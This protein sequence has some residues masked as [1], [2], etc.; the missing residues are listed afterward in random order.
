M[1]NRILYTLIFVGNVVF[2]QDPINL[3]NMVLPSPQAYE[4]VKYGNVSVDESSGRVSPAIPIYNYKAGNLELPISLN[5]SGNGVKVEQKP[6]WT[7]INWLL[8]AGGVITRVV[9][10][11]P[12]ETS[13]PRLF[14]SQE[15]LDALITYIIQYGNLTPPNIIWAGF[16]LPES[17]YLPIVAN[18][19]TADS[20]VDEFNFSFGNYSGSFFLKKNELGIFEAKQHKFSHD[21]KIEIIGNFSE[22]SNYEFKVTAPNGDSYFFGGFVD[23]IGSTEYGYAIEE[24]QSVDRTSGLPKF[25]KRAKTAFYLTKIENHLGDKIFLEYHTKA[26]HE[27]IS[28]TNVSM[29]QIYATSR[30]ECSAGPFNPIENQ[31]FIKNIVYNAKFLK[32]IWNNTTAQK[33]I[34][35]SFEVQ[36]TVNSTAFPIHYRILSSIDYGIGLA[37][38]EYIPTKSLLQNSM[39]N[40]EKFFLEKVVFKNQSNTSTNEEYQMEYHDPLE[41]PQNSFSNAQDYYGYYNGKNNPTLIP[42]EISY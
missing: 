19:E 39:R 22:N 29:K 32:Q 33:I 9:K 36:K 1:K 42:N 17:I 26:Q 31:N 6:T 15:Q 20:Q 38:F 16:I 12:D 11:L 14:Y 37:D 7:G 25:G 3:P 4:L 2:G 23:H 35:N 10:D 18:T 5:Y 28:A 34:F 40:R 41:I 13:N 21:L 30:P 27:L 24:T 8:N